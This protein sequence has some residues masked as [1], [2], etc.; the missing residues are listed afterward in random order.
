MKTYEETA[1]RVLGRVDEYNEKAKKRNKTLRIAAICQIIAV[2]LAGAVVAMAVTLR[3]SNDITDESGLSSVSIE[4]PAKLYFGGA[5]YV[6][7]EEAALEAGDEIGNYIGEAPVSGGKTG[8]TAELYAINGVSSEFAVAAK[9]PDGG[10]LLCC[11]ASY[12]PATLGELGRVLGFDSGG[13][14]GFSAKFNAASGAVNAGG[15]ENADIGEVTGEY[16]LD[17]A[18]RQAKITFTSEGGAVVAYLGTSYV[19]AR[20]SANTAKTSVAYVFNPS[21]NAPDP[22][23]TLPERSKWFYNDLYVNGYYSFSTYVDNG[24]GSYTYDADRKL[25]EYAKTLGSEGFGIWFLKNGFMA[26]RNDCCVIVTENRTDSGKLIYYAANSSD[27]S[28]DGTKSAVSVI[29]E[30]YPDDGKTSVT[31]FLPIDITPAGCYEATGGRLYFIPVL[32]DVEAGDGELAW[33]STDGG[34]SVFADDPSVL[35]NAWVS[36]QVF[37]ITPDYARNLSVKSFAVADIDGDGNDEFFAMH[38]D[39]ALVGASIPRY[40]VVSYENDRPEGYFTFIMFNNRFVKSGDRLFLEAVY[41][42][43][44]DGAQS[45][46]RVAYELYTDEY[47]VMTL[48]DGD[49]AKLYYSNGSSWIERRP[50]GYVWYPTGISGWSDR[51]AYYTGMESCNTTSQMT[52]GITA[53]IDERFGLYDGA[54]YTKVTPAWMSEIYGATI[55]ERTRENSVE[56]FLTTGSGIYPFGADLPYFLPRNIY[57]CDFDND[58][59]LELLYYACCGAD[60]GGWRI[61]VFDM[62]D[63]TDTVVIE[64]DSGGAESALIRINGDYYLMHRIITDEEPDSYTFALTGRFS[65]EEGAP[66]GVTY[67]A[68]ENAPI[69]IYLHTGLFDPDSAQGKKFSTF[70]QI[71]EKCAEFVKANA[72]NGA[73]VCVYNDSYVMGRVTGL[74]ADG[75]FVADVNKVWYNAIVIEPGK[76]TDEDVLKL[77][78]AAAL[79]GAD[80]YCMYDRLYREE[81][82]REPDKHIYYAEKYAT[83]SGKAAEAPFDYT[84]IDFGGERLKVYSSADENADITAYLA[85]KYP[86]K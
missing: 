40:V 32:N 79:E 33:G 71:Y 19:F 8:V 20:Q 45:E 52:D 81:S 61:G 67:E 86:V 28:A 36:P 5:E 24:D 62:D 22:P 68:I 78:C 55:Y 58:G 47:G 25:A 16:V 18:G 72:S 4:K 23:F 11:N 57:P 82:G 7:A 85:E 76:A 59:N 9:L 29:R 10:Y 74:P 2:L 15:E 35:A 6:Q 31:G 26:Y 84:I 43:Y 38:C 69:F 66:G 46:K 63:M 37:F 56:C 83:Y 21:Q 14:E 65:A 27:I 54:A 41:T 3:S 34:K 77:A 49:G 12:V 51:R 53:L 1:R 42:E 75:T 48:R 30:F 64:S 17:I 50:G 44:T 39:D 73:Y 80:Q 60:G 70:E 13:A